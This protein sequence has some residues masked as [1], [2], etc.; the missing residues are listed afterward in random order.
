MMPTN[1][2]IHA[3]LL[4]LEKTRILGS[5]RSHVKPQ[6]LGSRQQTLAK[7][8]DTVVKPRQCIQKAIVYHHRKIIIATQTAPC[9]VVLNILVLVVTILV[10]S[11]TLTKH[12]INHA[13]IHVIN[14]TTKHMN[15]HVKRL[16]IRASARVKIVSLAVEIQKITRNTM[17]PVRLVPSPPRRL[18]ADVRSYCGNYGR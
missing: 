4:I 18:P 14:L 15:I 12:V 9:V 1:N 6:I 5:S 2:R 17:L 10:L 13:I 3:G 11:T 16:L 8:R 7:S